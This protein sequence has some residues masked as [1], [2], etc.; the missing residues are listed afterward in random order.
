M[1]KVDQILEM[2]KKNPV[3][4]KLV[5]E[6]I[7]IDMK[8]MSNSKGLKIILDSWVPL[9]IMREKWLKKAVKMK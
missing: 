4:L 5:E 9:S 7:V 6:D 8:F 1:V 2:L 3:N